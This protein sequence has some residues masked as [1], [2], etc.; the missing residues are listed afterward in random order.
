M[1]RIYGLPLSA[2]PNSQYWK[3]ED[4]LLIPIKLDNQK[5]IGFFIL[6]DPSGKI[7]PTLDIV[8]IFG[9]FFHF[10]VDPK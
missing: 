3:N 9:E 10:L 7:R 2:H 8:Q 5:I 1:K 6:D 4:V